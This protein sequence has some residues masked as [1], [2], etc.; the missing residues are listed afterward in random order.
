MTFPR[1]FRYA[2]GIGERRVGVMGRQVTAGARSL[3]HRRSVQTSTSEIV[4]FL[5]ENLGITLTALLAS[6]EPRT[7]A[8]WVAGEVVP[9]EEAEK[10]LRSAYQIFHLLEQVEAS[11]T[12]RVWFM[13]MNEQ[14]A[15]LS[16][17][18]AIADGNARD[19]LIAARAFASYG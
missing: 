8:R 10:K 5:R 15:D 19:V 2:W 11:S 7:V 3:S 13:G 1:L 16:P 9:R 17:A 12:V 6:V 4:K 18:E 14:L